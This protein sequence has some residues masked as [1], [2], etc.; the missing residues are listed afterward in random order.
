VSLYRR[1]ID[2]MNYSEEWQVSLNCDTKTCITRDIS[3][4]CVGL[5]RWL[6]LCM[7]QGAGA[8]P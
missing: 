6:L 3:A 4:A 7:I 5:L 1:Y 2:T 8:D